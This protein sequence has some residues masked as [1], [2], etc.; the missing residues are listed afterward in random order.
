MAARLFVSSQTLPTGSSLPFTRGR[1]VRTAKGNAP[2]RSRGARKRSQKV[3]QKITAMR[4]LTLSRG[5]VENVG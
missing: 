3:P 5:E 4:R 2:V 1:K